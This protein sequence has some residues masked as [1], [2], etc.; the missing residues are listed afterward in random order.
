MAAK[1]LTKFSI[2]WQLL[3]DSVPAEERQKLN[4]L[5]AK[6]EVFARKCLDLPV[7]PTKIDWEY[8]KKH[9]SVSGMVDN[10]KN[11]YENYKIPFPPESG[12]AKI[13]SYETEVKSHIETYKKES[14]ERIKKMKEDLAHLNSLIPYDQMTMDDYYDAYPDEALDTLKRPSFWPHLPQDQLGYVEKT[15]E[16]GGDKKEKHH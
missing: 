14:E 10:F 11:E 12:S 1:R 4:H 8:Y 3:S 7:K 9:I 15:G 13:D 16:D 2:N 6:Y 5:R